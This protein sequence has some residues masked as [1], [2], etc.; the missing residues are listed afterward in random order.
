MNRNFKKWIA[1]IVAILA[2]VFMAQAVTAEEAQSNEIQLSTSA[3]EDGV[4][5][6]N[7]V[8]AYGAG[9]QLHE[10]KGEGHAGIG[11]FAGRTPDGQEYGG[12]G[13]SAGAS[14]EYAA[15]KG[16]ASGRIGSKDNNVNA[17]GHVAGGEVKGN[18]GVSGGWINGQPEFTAGVGGE[19]NALEFGGSA[20]AQIGGVGVGVYGG[21]KFGIGGKAYIG[22]KDGKFGF[23]AGASL[24][25][26][27]E[28]GFEVDI[29][30]AKEKI[31]K[32]MKE[33]V[34][35]VRDAAETVA[36]NVCKAGKAVADTTKK[37]VN[38]A[39]NAIRKGFSK[40][41]GRG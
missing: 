24:G 5:E 21:M 40:V 12:V 36:D 28:F 17:G 33:T 30:A 39:G 26:G 15:M 6:E 16:T 41:F 2:M 1:L 4:G 22:Y 14:G 8:Y 29:G 10:V 35:F 27:M 13:F 37:V 9:Y 19:V 23:G 7:E 32:G 38:A 18:V 3:Y 20:G 25:V 34:K 31:E 11:V